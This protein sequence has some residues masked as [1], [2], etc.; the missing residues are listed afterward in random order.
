M[1][2]GQLLLAKEQAAGFTGVSTARTAWGTL[3]SVVSF[4]PWGGELDFGGAWTAE[5]HAAPGHQAA[6]DLGGVVSQHLLAPGP[7]PAL[8]RG[9][10]RW[11]GEVDAH[12]WTGEEMRLRHG[13]LCELHQLVSGRGK[14][15][16]WVKVWSQVQNF[17]GP[18]PCWQGLAILDMGPSEKQPTQPPRGQLMGSSRAEEET[19]A[20]SQT[21]PGL[22]LSPAP[23]PLAPSPSH[24]G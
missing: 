8:P 1:S 16:F 12:T 19:P 10:R 3:T 17:Q 7:G 18:C 4:C 23:Q 11:G 2:A 13:V 9:S 24:E 20:L 22:S 6:P 14:I 5:S 15:Q 21:D